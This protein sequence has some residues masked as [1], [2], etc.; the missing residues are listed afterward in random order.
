M[1]ELKEIVQFSEIEL[2][3]DGKSIMV[4]AKLPNEAVVKWAVPYRHAHWLAGAIFSVSHKAVERQAAR[5]AIETSTIAADALRVETIEVLVKPKEER[6]AIAA[7]G[8]WTSNSAPGTT[9]LLVDSSTAQVLIDQLH[10]FLEVA[11]TVSRPS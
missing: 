3:D 9:A 8:S 1:T 11:P 5:G 10:R 2:S 6:A 7:L 4:T